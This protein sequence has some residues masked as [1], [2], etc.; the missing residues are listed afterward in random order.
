MLVLFLCLCSSE[1]ACHRR[2]N[3]GCTCSQQLSRRGPFRNLSGT[4]PMSPGSCSPVVCHGFY[5]PWKIDDLNAIRRIRYATSGWWLTYPSEKYDFVSWDDDLPMESHKI[6]WFQTT[7]QPF[8]LIPWQYSCV[9]AAWF[10]IACLTALNQLIKKILFLL[11]LP[12]L[13]DIPHFQIPSGKVT[14]ITMEKHN[15]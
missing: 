3:I 8:L 14:Y 6:P 12:L 2:R 9:S 11:G 15:F 13:G 4:F 1:T 7:N 10:Q 5:G